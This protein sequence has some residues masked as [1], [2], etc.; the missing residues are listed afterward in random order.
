MKDKPKIYINII[1]TNNIIRYH[2]IGEMFHQFC[3]D[4]TDL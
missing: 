1:Y 4:N 3:D 2:K